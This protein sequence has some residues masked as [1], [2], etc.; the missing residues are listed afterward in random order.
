[1]CAWAEGSRNGGGIANIQSN[2]AVWKIPVIAT[3]GNNSILYPA[4]CK[5]AGTLPAKEKALPVELLPSSYV[6]KAER[7]GESRGVWPHPTPLN[8]KGLFNPRFPCFYF[9]LMVVSKYQIP[10]AQRMYIAR[11]RGKTSP[12]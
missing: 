4:P 2:Q 10:K 12:V 11:Q 9:Y 5:V 1:M 6:E 7:P 3:L 8:Q